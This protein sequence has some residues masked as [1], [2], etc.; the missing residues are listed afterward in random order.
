MQYDYVYELQF[1]DCPLCAELS[2]RVIEF[3]QTIYPFRANRFLLAML[4]CYFFSLKSG[5]PSGR[6]VCAPPI[7]WEPSMP[8]SRQRA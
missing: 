4:S 5:I 3:I 6:S 1:L 7:F 8:G 2:R